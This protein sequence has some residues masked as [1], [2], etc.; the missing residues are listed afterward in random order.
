MIVTLVITVL[1]EGAVVIGYSL[2]RNKPVQPILLTSIF[3]NL[4]T[5]SFLWVVLNLFFQN[6]IITLILSE[7]LI[8]VVESALLYYIPAN[9]LHRTDAMILSLGMNLA[10]FALGWVLPV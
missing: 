2:W 6:Y 7:F 5:Q 3:G 4:I 9:H 1:V 8:W 10:S